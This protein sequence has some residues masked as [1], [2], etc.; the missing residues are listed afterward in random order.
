MPGSSRAQGTRCWQEEE[1]GEE[2]QR[3]EH[4]SARREL[5]F[6]LSEPLGSAIAI[7]QTEQT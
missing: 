3:D 4:R 6:V 1:T 2:P 7:E 5:A